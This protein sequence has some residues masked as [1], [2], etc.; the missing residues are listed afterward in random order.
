M[1][2][3]GGSS[4]LAG[5]AEFITGATK[6]KVNF[7]EQPENTVITGLDAIIGNPKYTKL[8]TEFGDR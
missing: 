4:R 1:Y 6:L 3:T 7:S 2:V 5:L 8:V